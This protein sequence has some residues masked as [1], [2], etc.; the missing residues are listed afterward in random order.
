MFLDALTSTGL[1]GTVPLLICVILCMLAAWRARR[2]SQGLADCHGYVTVILINIG[3][4]WVASKLDW[5]MMAYA[6]WPAPA[7]ACCKTRPVGA[8]QHRRPYLCARRRRRRRQ[9][10]ARLAKQVRRPTH[11]QRSYDDGALRILTITSEWIDTGARGS[12]LSRA[13]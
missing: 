13:R 1:F 3:G 5:L 12:R 6:P 7:S 2:G 10:R 4:N 9:Y 11:Q 8:N